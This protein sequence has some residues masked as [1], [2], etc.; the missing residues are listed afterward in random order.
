[1]KNSFFI[2]AFIITNSFSAVAQDK[3]SLEAGAL[4]MYRDKVSA[5]YDAITNDTYPKVF[6][7]V[8]KDKM[9]EALKNMMVGNGYTMTIVNTPPNFVFG[10]IKKIDG[11][12]YCM[13]KHDLLVKMTFKDP[14]SAEDSK[15]MIQNFKTAMQTEQVTFDAIENSFTMK[16]SAD[17]IAIANKLTAN[18][19]KFFNK[20]GKPLMVKVLGEKVIE[21]LGL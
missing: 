1:M 18:K 20:S 19:W 12:S 21:Q 14:V 15:E 3:K 2:I 13:V 11:G 17:V 10:K 6:D 9:I 16:E 8:P 7:I 4:Q 5:N